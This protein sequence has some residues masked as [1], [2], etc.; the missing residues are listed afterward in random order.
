[1]VCQITDVLDLAVGESTSA[2]C[3]CPAAQYC[4]R[5]Q[6]ADAGDEASPHRVGR[7]NRDLLPDDRARQSG[8][9]I[10]AR[11]KRDTRMRLDDAPDRGIALRERASRTRPVRWSGCKSHLLSPPSRARRA[12]LEHDTFGRECGA[13]AVG[14]GEILCFLGGG[15]LGDQCVDASAV[16]ARRTAQELVGRALQQASTPPSAFSCA[17]AAADLPRLTSPASSNSTDTASA[18][19]RSSS[20]AA[21]NRCACGSLQSTS[22]AGT[23]IPRNDV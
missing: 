2:Q 18:V 21:A 12:V 20:I 8:K 4:P 17:A 6:V 13:D 1:V 16:V 22:A 15:T 19:L 5:R 14:L 11:P 23:S 3:R 9:R 10:A 7:L